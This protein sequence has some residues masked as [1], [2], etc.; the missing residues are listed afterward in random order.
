MVAVTKRKQQSVSVVARPWDAGWEL[1]IAGFGV[2]QSHSL[3]DAP[4][5]V[6]DYIADDVTDVS[7]VEIRF[8]YDLPDATEA[9]EVRAELDALNASLTKAAAK[10][11]AIA[12]RLKARNLRGAD[13]A[14]VLGVSPQRVSQLLKSG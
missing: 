3:A 5:M 2:T 9:A 10:S 12:K 13:I 11:R 7:S 6:R 8:S 4:G 14:V 1:H